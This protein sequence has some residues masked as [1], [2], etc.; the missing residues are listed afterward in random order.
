MKTNKRDMIRRAVALMSVTLIILVLV[1]LIVYTKVAFDIGVM[2]PFKEVLGWDCP[3]CGGTRMAVEILHLNFYQAFR[4]NPFVF[5]TLPLIA[6][7]YVWQS[8]K[9]IVHNEILVWLDK[10]LISYAIA[11]MLFGILRN[12]SIFSWLAPTSI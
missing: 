5:I 6:T 2:C 8:Y 1:V 10:F 4:Y 7:V 3:G 12:T 11:L 9:F